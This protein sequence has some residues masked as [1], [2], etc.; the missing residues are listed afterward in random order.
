MLELG[1]FHDSGTNTADK[2][3][4][5]DMPS[6]IVLPMGNDKELNKSCHSLEPQFFRPR[7]AWVRCDDCHKWRCIP[8]ELAD[9]IEE[10]DCRW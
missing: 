6:S 5:K 3:P 4:C 10:T 7:L 8:A 9:E 1:I 2:V